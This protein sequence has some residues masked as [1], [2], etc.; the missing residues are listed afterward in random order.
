MATSGRSQHGQPQ[1]S[2][3]D[4]RREL[5]SYQSD[6]NTASHNQA[7]TQGSQVRVSQ[8]RSARSQTNNRTEPPLPHRYHRG[9]VLDPYSL[10]SPAGN[11]RSA[12]RTTPAGNTRS[13][14]RRRG[15]GPASHPPSYNTANYAAMRRELLSKR[16]P[17]NHDIGIPA[18]AYEAVMGT[19]DSNTEDTSDN[20]KVPSAPA[21][22]GQSENSETPGEDIIP[23]PPSYESLTVMKGFL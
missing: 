15:T 2:L 17:V 23:P 16:Q 12:G 7:T 4:L 13:A 22:A 9:A 21:A 8:P 20:S 11:T 10:T 1:P 18:P 3:A 6:R 5:F 14:G 19:S